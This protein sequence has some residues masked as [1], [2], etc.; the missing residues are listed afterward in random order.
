[1]KAARAETLPSGWVTPA[2]APGERSFQ[3]KSGLVSVASWRNWFSGWYQPAFQKRF[4]ST[5]SEVKKASIPPEFA[6]ISTVIFWRAWIS[7]RVSHL[8]FISVSVSNS[9]MFFSS[10]S[11]KGCLVSS[12]KSSLPWKR[13]QLKPCARAG[14]KTKGPAAAPAAA[15]ARKARRVSRRAGISGSSR[16][17]GGIAFGGP[18]RESEP[19]R[20]APILS[21]RGGQVKPGPRPLAQPRAR[22]HL[23]EDPAAHR[24]PLRHDGD[25][26]TD[27]LEIAP[28]LGQTALAPVGRAA[29]LPVHQVH[30]LAGAVG[31]VDGGQAAPG[32]LLQRGV[33][34]GRDR[35]PHFRDRRAAIRAARVQDRL[36]PADR[37]LHLRVVAETTGP[38]AWRLLDGQLDQ[39]VDAGP[40]DAGDHRAVMWPDPGLCR[41]RVRD[42]R[43]VAPLVVEW[44]PGGAHRPPLRQKD[45][46][47]RPVEA[48]GR[49]EPGH[50]PASRDD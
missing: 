49:T 22:V 8:T 36:G 23:H 50:V 15:A 46:V 7:G 4:F 26:L 44:D 24:V 41:Q 25:R 42:S 39:R 5:W 11:T 38:A 30:R 28:A 29:T 35:V 12:R 19:W 1:M 43:P 32:A 3:S 48:A 37:V 2:R 14:V 20:R 9:G 27:D 45:V 17:I 40:G 13:F 31:G 6:V 47:D 34:S 21:E 18:W 10:T 33:F 16:A